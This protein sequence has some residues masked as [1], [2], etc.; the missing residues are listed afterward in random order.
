MK[1]LLSGLIIFLFLAPTTLYAVDSAAKLSKQDEAI[2]ILAQEWLSV[3][4]EWKSKSDKGITKDMTYRLQ[5]LQQELSFILNPPVS[6]KI[7]AAELDEALKTKDWEKIKK[8]R[9]QVEVPKQVKDAAEAILNGGNFDQKL[10]TGRTIATIVKPS[11][12][13]TGLIKEA[14]RKMID[15]QIA[16]K[17]KEIDELTKMAD[18][19]QKA[20][21]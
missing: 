11:E 4:S 18:K 6:G 9:T 19:T 14:N 17:K 16:A 10:S 1:K 15:E 21:Q 2:G 12:S 20:G 7:I 8:L 13:L 5:V 3:V